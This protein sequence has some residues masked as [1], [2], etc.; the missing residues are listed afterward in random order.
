MSIEKK[1]I[2]NRIKKSPITKLTLGS[3]IAQMISILISP[4]TTRLYTPE[5]LGVYTLLITVVTLFGPILSGKIEM[6]IVTEK[7]EEKIYPIIVLSIIMCIILSITTTILYTIYII[8]TNQFNLEYIFYL[9]IIFIYLLVTGFSNI[10][11]S[12]NNRNKD[13]EIMSNVYVIRTLAQNLG[14]VVFGI[15]NFSITGMLL[16]QVFGSLLGLRKQSEKL[17]PN[18]EKIKKVKI[19]DLVKV[20]KENYKLLVYTSPATLCN[21]ASYSLLNFFINALYGSTVFGYYSISYRIL[22]LPLSLVSTNVSKVFFERASRE[23]N[24]KGN[25]RGTLNKITLLLVA[26]AIPMVIGL[27]FLA[28]AICE[29]VFGEGW[30][31]SGRYIQI[32]VFMFAI[33]LVVSALTPALVIIKKQKVEMKMQIAYLIMSVL[34]Y[35]ICKNLSLNV[36]VFLII[37]SITYSLIY[38]VIY[39]YI[40]KKSNGKEVVK[41]EN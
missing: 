11:I 6:A 19:E 16:S 4:I 26:V 39:I 27:G 13:Y 36:Y 12:Y 41:N 18:I 14:L 38:V 5:Q 22:G 3:L 20:F 28:P 17:L 15:L 31:V 40:Y 2:I 8:I 35:I 34:T 9:L 10:L 32:L 24:E 21:S 33:R 7:N 25:F 37:I 29:F 23:L 1:M 30:G